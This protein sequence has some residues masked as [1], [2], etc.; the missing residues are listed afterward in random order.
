MLKPA[1]AEAATGVITAANAKSP[2]DPSC[3]NDPGMKGY[4]AW[5][6]EWAPELNP[7]DSFVA[8]GYLYGTIIADLLR[9][10]GDVLTREN[11]MKQATSLNG[12]VTPLTLPGV[13]LDTGPD[14]YL[15]YKKLRLQ[16]FNGTSYTLIG[17]VIKG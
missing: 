2:G 3:D 9:R 11:L 7:N 13:T 6:K 1:G 15:P 4:Y 10:C 14:D 8:A 12:Y 5:A 17:G 16:Q